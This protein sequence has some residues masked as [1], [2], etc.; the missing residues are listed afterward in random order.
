MV[1]NAGSL[2]RRIQIRRF[3]RTGTDPYGSPTGDW[4]DHGSPIFARRRDVSDAERISGGAWDN[5]QV[6]RFV[7]RA[8]AFGR[9]IA[10]SDKL[11]HE[12]ITFVIDGIKEVPPGRAFLEITAITSES[13]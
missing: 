3:V 5:V 4:E 13:P 6:T 1:L 9:G 8:S 10:R 2:N 7:I 11:V 12:G